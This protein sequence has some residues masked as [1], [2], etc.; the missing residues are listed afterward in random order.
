MGD[1]SKGQGD[2]GEADHTMILTQAF[3]P[4]EAGSRCRFM[5]EQRS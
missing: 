4:S 3:A 2:V 1:E 5:A